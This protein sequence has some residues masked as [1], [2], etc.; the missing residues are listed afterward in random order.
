MRVCYIP[1]RES[2]YARTRIFING[3]KKNKVPFID[4]SSNKKS[5]LRYLEI[6]IKFIRGKKNSDIFLVGFLGQHMV[7][8]IRWFTKKKIVFDAFLSVYDTLV[9]DKKIVKQDSVAAKL[10]FWLDRKSCNIADVILLDTNQHI[11]YFHKTFGIRKDKFRRVLIGADEEIFYPRKT[12]EHNGFV[13]EFHGGFIPLQG[14]EYIV[15]A[16]KLLE[17][18]KDIRFNIIGDGQTFTRCFN[19]A[20]KLELNNIT[21]CGWKSLEEI[22]SYISNADIGLGVFGGTQ[23]TQRVIP[24]KAYE[25]IAMKKPL[26]TADTPAVRELF[27]NRKN[28]YLCK[29]CNPKAIAKSILNLKNNPE[30]R[31]RI[32]SEGHKL[33]KKFCTPA[34]IGKQL[35]NICE[36]LMI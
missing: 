32:A 6:F 12:K 10:F 4:C 1:G 28:V 29:Q 24:N 7:P 17:K 3:F 26:I 15:R 22:H 33:Y 14:V 34:I 2:T 16:A 27:E 35:K 20:K 23:K 31:K 21:F 5:N 18:H 9:F 19:L 11:E 36:D 13:V 25:I 30:L 8:I